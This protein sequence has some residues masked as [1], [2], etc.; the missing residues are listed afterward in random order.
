MRRSSG[1][2]S[3]C[4]WNRAAIGAPTNIASAILMEP[5]I[6]EKIVVIWL[7][8]TALHWPSAAEFN[9][10]QDVAASQLLFDCGVPMI[11]IP[12]TDVTSHLLTTV[13]EVGYY[14]KGKNPIANYLYECF[15]EFVEQKKCLSKVVWDIAAVACLVNPEWVPAHIVHS[16]IL[17]DQ[18]T[19]SMDRGRHFGKDA[20]AVQRD[21]IF[22]DVFSKLCRIG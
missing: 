17:S 13:H 18:L 6:I 16:P 1:F 5:G 14:L 10:E 8:G 7:G 12:C 11:R 20:F 2:W 22:L 9:L 21:A 19:W 15:Q 4:R 3:A